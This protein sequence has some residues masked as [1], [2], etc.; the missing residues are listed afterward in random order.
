MSSESNNSKKRR[1]SS[2]DTYLLALKM[3][4][5]NPTES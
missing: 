3:I 1:G 5:A 2:S 4:D